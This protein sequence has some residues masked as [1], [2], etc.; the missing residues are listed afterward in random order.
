MDIRLPKIACEGHYASAI[1]AAMAQS[2]PRTAIIRLDLAK[3]NHRGW[4]EGRRQAQGIWIEMVMRVKR[5]RVMGDWL[6]AVGYFCL[7]SEEESGVGP[8]QRS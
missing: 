6:R 1:A 5:N 4:E 8:G 3:T 7:K 2:F